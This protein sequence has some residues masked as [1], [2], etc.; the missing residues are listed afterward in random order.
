MANASF[1]LADLNG[2]NGFT[3]NGIAGGGFGIGDLSGRSVRRAGDINGDGIDD[4]IIGAPLA[5]RSASSHAGQS[6]VLFGSHNG[7]TSSLNLSSLNGSNGFAINGINR[8]DQSG[9]SV[10]GAGDINGDGIDDLIIGAPFAGPNGNRDA[11]QS[12]VIFGSRKGFGASFNL[13]SLNG[14]NGFAI[15]GI[16]VSDLAGVSVSGAGDVNGDGIADIIIGARQANAH[17]AA[18]AGQSYVIFGSRSGFS[19]SLN[20]SSLNGSNGFAIN[21]IKRLDY[22]GSSVSAAG[23][24]NGDGIADVIIGASTRAAVLSGANQSYVV[25]GSRSGFGASLDLSSLNGS[26]GFVI[27]SIGLADGSGV[28]VSGAGDINGDGIADLVVGADRA[29][30]DGKIN[31]GQSYVIFGKRSGFSPS[32]NL[33]SLNG[34]NGFAINGITKFGYSGSSVSGAGDIN[35][36]GIADLIIGA[37]GATAN[38]NRASG[39]SYV[40]YGSRNGFSP[41]FNLSSLNGSNGFAINGIASGDDAGWAVSGAGDINGDGIADLL[42]GAGQASPNGNMDAGQSY[43]I[44]GVRSG[45]IQPI[46][47]PSDHA[48]LLWRNKTS[49]QNAVWQL[50]TFTLQ[51][52]SYLPAVAD[53]NWQII[54]TADFNGDRTPDI[55]WRNQ[56]TGENA[57]WQMNSTGYQT[58]YYLPPVADM[59]WQMITTA[60]FNRDRTP[61]ILWRNQATG[62]NA[63]WQ[64]NGFSIQTAA[65]IATVA[66]AHWQIVG[67]ADFNSDGAADLLWR[68]QATGE[69]AIWQM[70][71]FSIQ[72]TAAIAT[73]AD[74]NWQIAGIA[75]FNHDATPDLVW[76]NQA[77][78]ENALWQMNST[79]FQSGY[80][81][82]AVSDTHWQIAGIADLGGDSTPDILWR[83]DSAGKAAIWQLSGFS[84]VQAYPLPD[85]TSGWSVKPFTTV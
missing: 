51:S 50:N 30:L 79:G 3:L 80:F 47:N 4:I 18:G 45:N 10:S 7:F 61:D 77:T 68:N 85:V 38:G 24:I 20:L 39:Q 53:A 43:V 67:A 74:V 26:N 52:G 64:M 28:S 5:G 11:G 35:G 57:I 72:T 6:Y 2:S 37:Y 73:V 81:L 65:F 84:Y 29:D 41:A 8:S 71:S 78:G 59:N 56:A 60:D 23:D 82:P 15:N 46:V 83:N 66:D 42:I 76:R 34:S 13:S 49:G 40:I 21:G 16:A 44:F 69:N 17:G 58:S 48:Q 22:S 14:S 27:N 32:F 70:N 25:F 9:S 12:Y 55:L 36:D 1:N 63:I 33:S 19:P 75:D 54:T 62:E 31:A